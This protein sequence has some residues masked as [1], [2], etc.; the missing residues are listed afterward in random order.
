MKSFRIYHIILYIIVFSITGCRYANQD[1]V[2]M[3]SY[4]KNNGEDGLHLA[5]SYD[6]LKWKIPY[7]MDG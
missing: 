6:G 5:Y 7:G 2:F 1:E 4:F 3:I